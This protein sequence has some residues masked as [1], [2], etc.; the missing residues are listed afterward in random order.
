MALHGVWVG[1]VHD[2]FFLFCFFISDK[3]PFSKK[4]MLHL[5]CSTA[6]TIS[7]FGRIVSKHLRVCA[8]VCCI[9]LFLNSSFWLPQA[10]SAETWLLFSFLFFFFSW[11]GVRPCP[12][13]ISVIELVSYCVWSMVYRPR[14]QSV[15]ENLH[16][17][18]CC[19]LSSVSDCRWYR[20]D[21]EREHHMH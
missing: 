11:V 14:V 15:H 16:R 9:P 20:I 6:K 17:M 10:L 5:I 12:C 1:N 18:K 7:P 21:I 8:C 19:L 4:L 2:C 3:A 13:W